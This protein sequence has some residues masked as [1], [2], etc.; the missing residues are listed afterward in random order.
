MYIFLGLFFSLLG[1][2]VNGVTDQNDFEILND[3]RNGLKNPELLK[4]PVRG[5]DPCGPPS[6]PHVFCSKNRVTQIQVQGLGLQGPL[7]QNLNQLDKLQNL[8]LQKNKF[9]GNL[10]TFSGLSDL[11]FAYLD[12]NEFDT[13]PADFFHGLSN[14]RVLALDENPFNQSSGWIIPSELAESF[15]LVNFSCSGCNIVGPLPD[16]FGKFPSL[17]SLRLSDNRLSGNIPSTFR[18]SMLQVLWLNDQEGD[19]MNGPIDVIGTM[20]GLTSVWLHGNQFTGSI[21]DDIGRLTSLKELNLNRNRLVGLIP[22]S[23]ANMNLRLLNLNNNMFMG[24]IPKFKAGNV[25]YASNSFCQ[26]D[27]GEQCAPEVTALLD[28]LHDLNYPDR[29]ASE[30]SGNDPCQEPW[31]GISC[32]AR[33]EVSVINLQRLGLNGTLSPSLVNLPSLLEI[34][35]EGNNLHGTVPSNLTRLSVLRLLNLSGNNFEPPLPRFRDG[36]KVVIDGNAKFQAKGPSPVSTP[37]PSNSPEMTPNNPSSGEYQPSDSPSSGNSKPNSPNSPISVNTL[38][39]TKPRV[40]VIAAAAAGSTVSTLLA[41]VL[42]KVTKDFAQENELGR[43]GFGVV[44]KGELE[45]GAKLAVKRMMV[46]VA[47]NKARYRGRK[48]LVLLLMSRGVEYLHTLAHQSFIHR[49][50]KS[51]NILLDDDFRAKV[52]DFGLVKLAPGRDMSVATRLAGTFGYL[53]P[54]YAGRRIQLR[55]GTDGTPDR[56]SGT[57]RTPSRRKPILGRVVL[58]DKI[59]QRIAYCFNRPALDAKEDIY[60]TIYSIATLA[61]HCTARDPNHR[62]EMGHAVNV[63]AQLVEKWKPYEETDRFSGINMTLPLPQMLKGWQDEEEMDTQD[64]SQDSKGSIPAKPSGFADSFTSA[65]AR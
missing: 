20:V 42:R 2:G 36:V 3:F 12:F 40:L 58:A 53:A 49:D 43:G 44:Y 63:L 60:E 46:G 61:G 41:V 23:L 38:S 51:A 56:A 37:S 50:L 31:W 32:N 9:N 28:F 52:S 14:I 45:D 13:I 22:I 24:P 59:Q 57:R 7:P 10:P 25:S 17:V 5:N 39:P 6:W 29:L 62:P 47:C 55:S 65:D 33:N 19:G 64:F 26:S 4:W 16:F 1:G 34:H 8:G 54:E 30:W 27:P 11:Q 15:Q 35:L 21:P 18:D 48:G